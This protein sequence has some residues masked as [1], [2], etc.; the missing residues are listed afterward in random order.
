MKITLNVD[1]KLVQRAAKLAGI[2]SKGTLVQL[3][4][5]ALIARESA[6]RLIKLGGAEPGLAPVR[7]RRQVVTSERVKNMRDRKS[8]V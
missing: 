2:S 3:G 7:R 1:S 5:E 6:R 4:L 8:V